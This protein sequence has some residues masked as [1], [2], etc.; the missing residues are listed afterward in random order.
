MGRS[1]NLGEQTGRVVGGL[2]VA[3]ILAVSI[4]LAAW[5]L[6]VRPASAETIPFRLDNETD[7]AVCVICNGPWLRTSAYQGADGE[8]TTRFYSADVNFLSPFGS[9]T[10]MVAKLFLDGCDFAMTTPD[11]VAERQFCLPN[12]PTV[13]DVL[14]TLRSGDKLDANF[15]GGSCKNT[16]AASTL[17]DAAGPS[18]TSGLG[19]QLNRLLPNRGDRDSYQVWAAG[20]DELEILLTGDGEVGHQG[21]Q[22]I[23]LLADQ[24]ARFTVLERGAPPLEIVATLPADGLYRIVVAPDGETGQDGALGSGAPGPFRGG[25]RLAVTTSG[26]SLDLIPQAD[27]EP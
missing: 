15:A 7:R 11:V 2:T 1:E 8:A 12:P 20:G 22:L 3:Q 17:G 19:G 14:L 24:Q 18:A 21:D 9:W 6:A 13:P 16:L 10:C 23:L 27:V 5:A 25:Y 4:A 26:E